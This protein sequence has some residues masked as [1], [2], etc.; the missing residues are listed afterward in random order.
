M[1]FQ[2]ALMSKFS[3]KSKKGE[4]RTKSLVKAMR[5]SKQGVIATLGRLPDFTMGKSTILKSKK[6]SK[7]LRF[8]KF[9]KSE[10]SKRELGRSLKNEDEKRINVFSIS[11][12]LELHYAERIQKRAGKSWNWV[13]CSRNCSF[14]S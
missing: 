2:E 7:K 9:E 14:L 12:H 8:P 4:E 1:L 3:T 10:N 11:H 6:K 13:F 5:L